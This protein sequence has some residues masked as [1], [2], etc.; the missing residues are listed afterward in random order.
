MKNGGEWA[1]WSEPAEDFTLRLP[2]A[3]HTLMSCAEVADV[4]NVSESTLLRWTSIG[5]GP[6]YYGWAKT[7]FFR[8]VEVEEWIRQE[9]QSLDVEVLH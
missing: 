9:L 8:S 1:D 7:P 5:K 4:L 3:H 2:E 6:P